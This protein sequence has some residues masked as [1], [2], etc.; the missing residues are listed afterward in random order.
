MLDVSGVYGCLFTARAQRRPTW[1]LFRGVGIVKK[2]YNNE[3]N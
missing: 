1:R 3:V 2:A